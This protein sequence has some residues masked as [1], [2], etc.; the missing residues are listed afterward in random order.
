MRKPTK[1]ALKFQEVMLQ[2]QE[3]EIERIN[4]LKE[5]RAVVEELK[6][7]YSK[8]LPEVEK[9]ISNITG[10]PVKVEI[11]NEDGRTN[12]GDIDGFAI[13]FPKQNDSD[14]Q[15]FAYVNIN[16]IADIVGKAFWTLEQ[17]I[18]Q[19]MFKNMV[20]GDVYLTSMYEKDIDIQFTEYLQSKNNVLFGNEYVIENGALF[21]IY[22]NEKIKILD[23]IDIKSFVPDATGIVI[24]AHNT[25]FIFYSEG[26]YET[27]VTYDDICKCNMCK[28]FYHVGHGVKYFNHQ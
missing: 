5:H 12:V 17:A 14:L 19:A 2:E 25:K 8:D 11:L 23:V 16:D 18:F 1:K 9:Y 26:W 15:T 28:Y 4:K 22:Y 21:E 13:I 7:Q 24:I 6:I 27:P 10:M 3:M 20:Y